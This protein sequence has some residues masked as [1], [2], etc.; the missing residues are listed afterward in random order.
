MAQNDFYIF[1]QEIANNISMGSSFTSD[2]YDINRVKG[3]TIQFFWENGSS[4]VGTMDILASNLRDEVS[5]YSSLLSS[6]EALS[7]NSGSQMF[8]I[9]EPYYKYIKIVYTR[10]SG[11]GELS[12]VLNGKGV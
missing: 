8:N 5:S 11:D 2:A 4:P 6:P 7:G 10:T 12:I 9:S 1:H 3:L